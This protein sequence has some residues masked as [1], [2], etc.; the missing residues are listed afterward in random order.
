MKGNSE[1]E[2]LRAE[3]N[4]LAEENRRL[5]VLLKDG[6]KMDLNILKKENEQL[7]K[8]LEMTRN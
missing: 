1:V 7:R 4:A 6:N 3:K 2:K 5:T 8:Q